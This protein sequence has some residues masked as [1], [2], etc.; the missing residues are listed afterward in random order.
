MD[1]LLRELKEVLDSSIEEMSN[2]QMKWHPPGKWSAAEVL[3][4][5]YLTYTGTIKGFERVMDAG[6]PLAA[7]A[8]LRQR[9]RTMLV[10]GFNYFPEGRKAPGATLPRGLPAEQVRNE[11]ALKIAAM[12]EIIARSEARFGGAKLLDHPILGPLTGA[13]W[14]RFHLIHGQHHAKQITR[15]REQAVGH[16]L[17]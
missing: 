7:R 11:T 14:R 16:E 17:R 9:C 2:E 12:D 8:S 13:Q 15:L 3:E 4:H 5:L 10:F 6:K 1:S